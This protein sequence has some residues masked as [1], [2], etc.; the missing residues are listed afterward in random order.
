MSEKLWC[1]LW[2]V[3]TLICAVIAMYNVTGTG[4]YIASALA[5]SVHLACCARLYV[6]LDTTGDEEC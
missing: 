1:L 2:V 5:V 4:S 6:L 3:L